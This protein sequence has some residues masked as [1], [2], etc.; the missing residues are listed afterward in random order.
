M[1]TDVAH[2]QPS[3]SEVVG[4]NTRSRMLE[5]LTDA[6]QPK[7]QYEL[8]EALDISQAS[9]SRA[10][11]QLLDMGVV[12]QSG[13]GELTINENVESG[14]NTFEKALTTDT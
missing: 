3:F 5:F 4:E 8:A 2:G 13:K 11:Q 1:T 14:I 12:S 10:T 7:R 9:V 6:D